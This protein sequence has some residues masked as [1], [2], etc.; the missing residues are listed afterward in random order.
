[1]THNEL[2]DKL[3]TLCFKTL[4]RN[5]LTIGSCLVNSKQVRDIFTVII[6]RVVEPA[7]SFGLDDLNFSLFLD[8]IIQVFESDKDIGIS[9][10]NHNK[11]R[12]NIVRLFTG[13]KLCAMRFYRSF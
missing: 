2:I 12:R 6:E 11:L 10:I 3:S 1:M 7:K 5:I 13:I 4:L 8:G 9:S